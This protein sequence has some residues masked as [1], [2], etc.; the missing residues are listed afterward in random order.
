MEKHSR[1][2]ALALSLA[3]AASLLP[4]S[5]LAEGAAS[6]TLAATGTET[7]TEQQTGNTRSGADNSKK[8]DDSSSSVAESAPAAAN[9]APVKSS[10]TVPAAITDVGALKEAV[11]KGGEVKL[12]GDIT[13]TSTLEIGTNT[14][15]DTNGFTLAIEPGNGDGINVH[16]N[17][18][19]TLTDSSEAG[20][21]LLII[22]G[23]KTLDT[24]ANRG[25]NCAGNL[26]IKSGTVNIQDT[27]GYGI[28][29]ESTCS[30]FE[31]DGGTLNV[32]DCGK[33]AEGGFLWSATGST[34]DFLG[35]TV[36]MTGCG[37]ALY[38]CI[39]VGCPLTFGNGNDALNVN[40][41]NA[42]SAKVKNTIVL[43]GGKDLTINKNATVNIKI[44]G[45]G[46][47]CRGINIGDKT[48]TVAVNGG[49][50]NISKNAD[51]KATTVYGIR[52]SRCNPNMIVASDSTV[53]ISGCSDKSA[54]SGMIVTIDGGS[55][56]L[57]T[58]ADSKDI[59]DAAA[60][61]ATSIKNSLGDNVPL[62]II[63][64]RTFTAKVSNAAKFYNYSAKSDGKIYAWLP[65]NRV[66]FYDSDKRPVSAVQPKAATRPGLS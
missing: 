37:S 40:L 16:W 5:A 39:Y 23:S 6:D 65:A 13:L 54:L 56:N 4:A 15:I 35:G 44:A 52:G 47:E 31:M 46:Q 53:S 64:A 18:S 51:C 45:A 66:S 34:C 12:G 17:T 62:Q 43:V 63:D 19:L 61:G 28:C 14:T 49:T 50:L 26:T 2:L 11:A 42:P 36:K 22:D 9:A 48:S 57:G 33:G 60:A 27:Q 8:A 20:T 32:T 29:S 3:L 30:V 24:G 41:E 1:F 25:I 38:G 10:E 59:A 55:M 58:D 7:V 21:G